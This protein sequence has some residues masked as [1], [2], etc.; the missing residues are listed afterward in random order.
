MLQV[1]ALI[2]MEAP[3]RMSATEVRREKTK[4][5][6]ATRLGHKVIFG[7]YDTY[8]SEEGVDPNSDTPT[9][10]AG[11]LYIDNWRWQGVPFHFMSGK[12]MPYQCVEVVIK[13]KSP[14][15][16][17]FEGHEYDDRIVMRF[18]PNPH[19]DVRINMKAPGLGDNVETATLTHPYPEGAVDGYEKLLYDALINDQSHFVH[20]EEVLESWRI[21]DDLLCTG[22][23]CPIRTTP[24]VY[25]GG[26]GPWHKTESI[27]KW[28]YPA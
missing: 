11:D 17:L 12:K 15:M 4:V 27:T 24:Y 2:A 7:Q 18:Q 6:A 23:T 19:L 22:D 14:P 21:V 5:L 16:T 3:C 8:K 28:D 1:L 10:V 20:S 13:L 9:F 25:K 26:W